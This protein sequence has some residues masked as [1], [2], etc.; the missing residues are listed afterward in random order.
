M[1]KY[2]RNS[3]VGVLLVLSLVLWFS[4]FAKNHDHGEWE[5]ENSI[6]IHE[7]MDSVYAYLSNSS[8]ASNWSSYVHHITPLNADSLADG[9]LG[10]VRR[11]FKNENEKGIVWD[12]EITRIQKGPLIY[13]ELSIFKMQNFPIQT[14]HLVTR[15]QY[16]KLDSNKMKLTFGLYKLIDSSDMADIIKLKSSG[17]YISSIFKN[18]LTNIK[19]QIENR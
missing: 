13:R 19:S 18:N 1:I 3:V 2:F 17:Y 16:E 14:T 9:T 11:C 8:N 6:I 7:N 15:Q 12:E 10:S 5:M 4:P